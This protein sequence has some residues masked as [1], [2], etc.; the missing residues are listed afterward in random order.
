[1]EEHELWDIFLTKVPS[2][3][4]KNVYVVEPGHFCYKEPKHVGSFFHRKIKL[5]SNWG[6]G[7]VGAQLFLFRKLIFEQ[8]MYPLPY[9]DYYVFVVVVLGRALNM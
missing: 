2:V 3:L 5:T 6:W 4:Q 9:F 1:M 8:N 7:G